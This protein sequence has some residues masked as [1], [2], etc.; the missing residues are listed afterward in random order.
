MQ[1][2][3]IFYFLHINLVSTIVGVLGFIIYQVTYSSFFAAFLIAMS[4]ILCPFII[5]AIHNTETH[6]DERS[7]HLWRFIKTVLFKIGMTVAIH[8][9]LPSMSYLEEGDGSLLITVYYVFTAE[10]LIPNVV[11][12]LDIRSFINHHILAPRGKKPQ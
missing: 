12:I 2:R 8:T 5:S 6:N 11:R 7:D 3:Y 4:N 1:T 10:L 9:V